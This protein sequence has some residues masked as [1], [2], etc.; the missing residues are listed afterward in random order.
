MPGRAAFVRRLRR[1]LF[2]PASLGVKLAMILAAAGAVGAIGVTLILAA[3]V[4]PSLHALQRAETQ[5][6]LDRARGAIVDQGLAVERITHNLADGPA[7][8][9]SGTV[10]DDAAGTARLAADGGV[11]GVTWREE[12]TSITRS[13]RRAA[14]RSALAG[15]DLPRVLHGHRSGHVFMRLD[16]ALVAIGV[17]TVR[18]G[19][20]GAAFVAAARPVAASDLSR[21]LRRPVMLDLPGG[22]ASADPRR[23]TVPIIGPDRHVVA[24][25]GIDVRSD[26][27]VL[28]RRMLLLAIGGSILLILVLLAVLRR[29]IA[30]MVLRPLARMD[31]HMR[32]VRDHG[33][34]MMLEDDRRRDEIGALVRSHNAMLAQ[35]GAL[36]EQVAVQ[37][38]ALGRSEN[39]VAVIHNVRNALSPISTILSQGVARAAPVDRPALDRALAELA[40]GDI[41]VARR[42]KLVAFVAAAIEA[43]ERARHANRTE[44]QTGREAMAQ[45]LAIIGLQQ[46]HALERPAL[47]SCDVAEVI[48]RNATIARYSQIA[49]IG[50]AFPAAPS[51]VF[52]N[53]L[54]LS[55]VVGNLFVN[56]A[57]A[58]AAT[59]RGSGTI[60]VTVTRSG[61]TVT[62]RIRDDGEGFDPAVAGRL[63]G[64]G[65]STRDHKS[66]G[67]GLHWCAN[68]MMSMNGALRLESEGRGR[69]ACAVLTLPAA[70]ALALSD[71]A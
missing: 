33:T 25:I 57:E 51:P 16:G 4:T 22:T 65:Y 64:R 36:R 68:A 50:F 12:A 43:E 32:L 47:Q 48:A 59:G 34:L 46:Q 71:A 38:F 21:I 14:F 61:D 66:G 67:L 27:T 17:A 24:V 70:G 15:L 44:L 26:V 40:S 8:A 9:G 11:L 18:D 2:R 52:A 42:H 1:R 58:I 39:A 30:H 49:S 35:L 10:P 7:I 69:G 3:V 60:A 37:G 63:F 56:A 62:I 29:A 5:A 31:R 55:Q 54:I 28:G 13:A 20:P 19:E 23:A 53:C 45:A 41:P 6:D